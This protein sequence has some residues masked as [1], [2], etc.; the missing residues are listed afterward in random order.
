MSATLPNIPERFQAAYQQIKRLESYERYIGAF[1]FGSLAR[2]E[3]AEKSDLDVQVLV[4]EDNPCNNIN[5]PF[6]NGV[7]LD[8]SFVSLPQLKAATKNQIRKRERIPFIAESLIVFDKSG[9]L[10]KLQEMARQVRPKAITTSD[11]QFVQ[12][13]FYHGNNKVERYLATDP[14]TALFVM[15]VGLNDFLQF[16]YQIHQR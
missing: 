14:T 13:M 10:E 1:I 3:A 12:F 8:L 5:H 9:E 15:H 7:R 6:I 11:H 16:H 2:C 4:D